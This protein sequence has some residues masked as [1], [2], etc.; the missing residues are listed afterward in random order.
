MNRF[1]KYLC[2]GV[3]GLGLWSCSSDEPVSTEIPKFEGNQAVMNISI[4]A[5]SDGTRADGA[6][7]DYRPGEANENNIRKLNFYFYDKAGEYV[8]AYEGAT[9]TASENP[10]SGL[11]E[12]IG[13]SKVVL[14]DLLGQNYPS[15]V[16]AV[17]NFNLTGATGAENIFKKHL[18]Q[19]AKEARITNAWGSSSGNTITDFV[20]TSATHSNNDSEEFGYF[21]TR[22]TEENFALQ[23]DGANPGS[24][25]D[26]AALKA[27]PVEI[28]VERLAS[29]VQV[30]FQDY[31]LNVAEDGTGY[32]QVTLP[33]TYSVDGTDTQL[34][35]RLYGWGVNGTA[36]SVKYF[37]GVNDAPNAFR[38]TDGWNYDGTNRSYW[39]KTPG[40]GSNKYSSSFG[41]VEDKDGVAGSEYDDDGAFSEPLNYI[42]WE[43][44]KANNFKTGSISAYV[45][46]HTEIGEQLNLSGNLLRH[47]AVTEILLAGQIVDATTGKGVTLFQLS[48][49][50]YTE[51]GVINYL[52][53]AAGSHIWKQTADNKFETI[54][55]EDVKVVYGY[56]GTFSL[57]LVNNENIWYHDNEGVSQWVDGAAVAN[58]I[59]AY[60][61]DQQSYCYNDGLLYY[62]IPIR[63]LRPLPSS[64]ATDKTIRTGMYGVVRNHWYQVTVGAIKNLGHSVYRPSEHIIPPSDDTRYMIGSTVKILSWRVVKSNVE[65]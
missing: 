20:M 11:V 25:W 53:N 14:T 39:A 6:T 15:Y 40:Y 46:P 36:K 29:K 61:P 3:L 10:G 50:Y 51:D 23:P 19:V 26:E 64:T 44:V 34:T 60:L 49:S 12:E 65:L 28:Y 4:M 24:D 17:I 21:A 57:D 41:D 52:L 18:S 35:V 2:I 48:D 56:D 47:S 31:E 32:Y 42:S 30:L 5:P 13:T 55:P 16:V 37:K 43:T 59:N 45:N 9:Y 22:I 58:E 54:A 38:T 7:A 62:N 27:K 33:G 8:T 63:H 1:S